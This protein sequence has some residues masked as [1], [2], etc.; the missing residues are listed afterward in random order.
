MKYLLPLFTALVIVVY[1][2]CG[3]SGGDQ[4][5]AS[6]DVAPASPERVAKMAPDATAGAPTMERKVIKTAQLRFRTYDMDKTRASVNKAIRE[7]GGYISS[8]NENNNDYSREQYLD[9]RVPSARL[10]TFIQLISATA[11]DWEVKSISAADVTEEFIDVTARLNT[12]KELETRYLDLLRRAGSVSDILQVEAQLASVRGE[13]ESM[14]GRLK[15]LNSQVDYS[16][17]NLSYYVI[18]RGPVGFFGRMGEG[19]VDG[20]RSL[21]EF[22]IGLMRAW[23]FVLIFGGLIYW[24]VKRWGKR[25]E[26]G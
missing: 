23:P 17:V 12:K 25:R 20:W 15:Y 11:K 6:Y 19:F 3:H 5:I 22:M 16:T 7:T 14:E 21:L 18:V 13:I 9:I 2:S 1:P 8:E 24:L 26:R 10:D 4:Q